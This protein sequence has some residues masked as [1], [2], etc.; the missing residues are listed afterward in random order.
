MLY[1]VV[2]NPKIYMYQLFY[3]IKWASSATRVSLG[4]CFFRP[5]P[6][7]TMLTL[8]PHSKNTH[9]HDELSGPAKFSKEIE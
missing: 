7:A 2:Q 8:S 5:L 4:T 3:W 6:S 9:V 1:F